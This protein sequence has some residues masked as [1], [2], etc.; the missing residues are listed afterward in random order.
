[1]AETKKTTAAEKK[2]TAA[3]KKT[4]AAKKTSA[5]K[6]SSSAKKTSAS[7][8]TSS[9]GKTSSAKKTSSDSAL[10]L[11]AAEKKLIQDYRKCGAV[12]KKMISAAVDKAAGGIAGKE[13]SGSGFDIS[14]ILGLFG[15]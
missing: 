13:E 9:A 1:M 8:K 3:E 6:S 11:T 10:K 15:K 12:A 4:A 7:K 2:T 14:S 5:S